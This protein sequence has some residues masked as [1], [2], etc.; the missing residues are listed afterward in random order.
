MLMVV[1][2]AGAS[3]G[4]RPGDS[5]VVNTTTVPTRRP[6]LTAGLFSRELAHYAVK[7]PSSRPAIV[8]LRA[9]LE[10]KPDTLIEAAIGQLYE[11]A[12][13][14]PERARH[15]LALRFYLC[16]LIETEATEWW[17]RHHGFTHYADLLARLGAWRSRTGED[18]ALVTFNYDQLLDLSAAAQVG[19]WELATFSSYV[20][21]QDWRLY[22]LHGST[23]WSR[24]LKIQVA[25]NQH[26]PNG[27]IAHAD[28][29]NPDDGELHPRPWSR[30]TEGML[31]P[32]IALP[33]IA[34]PTDRKDTFECPGD[35]LDRFVAD[36]TKTDR[37]LMIGW[38]AAEPHARELLAEHLRPGYHLAVCGKGEHDIDAIYE[39]LGLAGKRGRGPLRLAHGFTGLLAGSELEHWLN[40]DPA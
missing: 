10:R 21:R 32:I 20:D 29:F 36:I 26:L 33:A 12:A 2:G 35:H 8:L 18:I 19:N 6:P 27:L 23:G 4:S 13:D 17:D 40:L 37:V 31:G 7:Y 30:A 16:D 22:K 15:L 5:A 34:V 3:F 14:D 9:E 1:F 25:E 28:K 24:V 11:E 38:R 39:N